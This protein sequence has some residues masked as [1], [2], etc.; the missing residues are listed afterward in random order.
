MAMAATSRLHQGHVRFWTNESGS[1]R[2]DAKRL[3]AMSLL[4]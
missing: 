4:W 1:A 3:E 2:F